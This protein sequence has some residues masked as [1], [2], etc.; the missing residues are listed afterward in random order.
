VAINPEALRRLSTLLDHAFDLAVA[1]RETWLAGLSGEDA[2]LAPTLRELLAR[3][4]SKETAELFEGPPA[5]TVTAAPLEATQSRPGDTVGAYRLERL[6]GRGGMGEVWLAE[7]VDGSLKRKVAL[8]L[9]HVTW[10]PGLAERFA[11]EREILSGLEH[12]NIARLYDAGVDAQ[13]RP[14]MALEYVEGQPLDQ[15]C[16]AGA[17]SIEARLKLLLQVAEAMAFAHSRLVVHRDLKPGNMLVTADGQVRLLDF[18]IAKLMEGDRTRET[19][20]TQ[21][22][23]RALTLDYASPEQIRGEQIGTAS[24]VYSLGVVA[25]ELLA[26]ARPYRL[27][28]GSAAELEEAITGADAPLASEV[29]ADPGDRKRLKGDLDAI[30]NKALKK[31]VAERYATIDALAQDWRRHLGGHAVTARPDTLRYRATRFARRHRVP[32]GAGGVT[33]AAFGLALGFGAMALVVLA[34]LI[35]LGAALWQARRAHEQA[36]RAGQQE[37]RAIAVQDFLLGLFRANADAQP[38]P[39]R[40]RST[41]AR[42]L[43]DIGA[44]Q[45]REQLGHVPEAKDA[46][47]STLVDMYKDVGLDKEAA[48]LA[49]ERVVLLERLHG[50]DDPRVAA[51]LVDQANAIDSTNDA[52]RGPELLERARRIADRAPA[53]AVDLRLKVLYAQAQVTRY[54]DVSVSLGYVQDAKALMRRR[55]TPGDSLR[56]G[57]YMEGLTLGFLG[58]CAEGLERLEEAHRISVNSD[59]PMPQW[60]IPEFTAIF[61]NAVAVGDYAR[62]ESA[63]EEALDMSRRLNGPDHTDT[64]HVLL[65]L[66]R[67]YTDTSRA[68][69]ARDIETRLRS[70]LEEPS[71]RL[72]ANLNVALL[73]ALTLRTWECGR[74]DEAEALSARMVESYRRFTGASHVLATA[75]QMRARIVAALGRFDEAAG[76]IDEAF[77]MLQVALG[78]RATPAGL[79]PMRIDRAAVALG[80]GR[81]ADGLAMLDEVAAELPVGGPDARTIV[82]ALQRWRA[83]A[84]RESGREPDAAAAA[85]SGLDA[86]GPPLRPADLPRLRA[87]LL[88]ERGLA[89]SAL[90]RF[91]E[92]RAAELAALELRVANDGER[93]IWRAKV[94]IALAETER[95][96]GRLS[97]VGAHDLDGRPRA[98][99]NR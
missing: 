77:S 7:R 48:D 49:G 17:L 95:S 91:A 16:K 71:T 18:G 38:D 6:L 54:T 60:Q 78:A 35:G 37:E 47:L 65:R 32:L 29:A 76:A 59:G 83:A 55:G 84:L 62:A 81:A 50:P 19:A 94:E 96:A 31:P 14:Y 82:P 1:E 57:L 39:V 53:D 33:V 45:V 99:G 67:V 51:A 28:R 86:M 61:S 90:G 9:P 70:L 10:A 40:A 43:L 69:E 75:M 87:D 97:G 8:K 92:A 44:R 56:R 66:L 27:K 13:G 85:Q 30:L 5:F 4:G 11:R 23:G 89:L 22:S 12:P 36:R 58:A 20:L 34:L 52:T 72:E 21:V 88:L 63:L 15:F 46:V 93:S 98:T 73:R 25:Y 42:E 41:T 2:V 64:T 26:G 80:A 79:A 68:V 74:L 3:Q 24:D